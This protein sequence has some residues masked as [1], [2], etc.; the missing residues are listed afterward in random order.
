MA[1][2]SVRCVT[3][4]NASTPA[5][6]VVSRFQVPEGS[7]VDFARDARAAIQALGACAGFVD[8][9]LGQSTDDPHLR[10]IVTRWEGIGA[11]RRSLS[12]YEV[13]LTAIPL[14]STAVDEESAFEVVHA[15]TPAGWTDSHSGLAADAGSARLGH[16]AGPEVRGVVS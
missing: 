1:S 11:Y 9:A 5:L 14:L 2:T 12:N 7:E 15:R 3:D 8:A 6:I 10:T 4:S 13:K 16:A